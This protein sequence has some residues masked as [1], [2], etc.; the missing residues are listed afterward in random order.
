MYHPVY[1]KP[2]LQSS[3]VFSKSTTTTIQLH[4]TKYQCFLGLSTNTAEKV[5]YLK[6]QSGFAY[7]LHPYILVIDQEVLDQILHRH[8]LRI[9]IENFYEELVRALFE[10]K[11]FA[12]CFTKHPLK[13]GVSTSSLPNQYK[14]K[15][16]CIQWEKDGDFI[17]IQF[18]IEKQRAINLHELHVQE[19]QRKLQQQ[20]EAENSPTTRLLS[21]APNSNNSGI[22]DNSSLTRTVSQSSVVSDIS[23]VVA[24]PGSLTPKPYMFVMTG[25]HL[26]RQ[27]SDIIPHVNVR[28]DEYK[29]IYEQQRINE[30]IQIMKRK[31]KYDARAKK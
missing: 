24:N 14:A 27:L 29:E 16:S 18:K 4:K 1:A 22:F 6:F 31:K 30:E 2:P 12:Y 23:N 21:P 13:H 15:T 9:S 20:Q 25:Y 26:K 10:T 19:T 5:I 7:N 17:V 8:K 11:L 3:Y 28:F